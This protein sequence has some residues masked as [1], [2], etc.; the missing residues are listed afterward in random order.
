MIHI[1]LR[2]HRNSASGYVC[3]A[4]GNKRAQPLAGSQLLMI[5][6]PVQPEGATELITQP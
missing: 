2:R 1:S 4:V 6:Q 3:C 5:F